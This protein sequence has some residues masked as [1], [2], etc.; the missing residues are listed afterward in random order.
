MITAIIILYYI[1][2][3]FKT[4]FNIPYL[5]T[6]VGCSSKEYVQMLTFLFIFYY[7]G[8]SFCQD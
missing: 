8:F 3:M 6:I 7:I 4:S 2:L 1:I 5:F